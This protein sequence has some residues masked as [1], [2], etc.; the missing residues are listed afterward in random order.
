MT[1]R[2]VWE[3][4][5]EEEEGRK[6]VKKEKKRGG[7]SLARRRRRGDESVKER[8]VLANVDPKSVGRPPTEG[9][10]AVVGPPAG[11]EKRGATGAKGVA[12]E[13][14]GQRMEPGEVPSAGRDRTSRVEPQ[15]GLKRAR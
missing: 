11:S 4:L 13:G 2:T 7:S 9:L 10:D 5:R 12:T 15:K 3:Y 8:G 1:A 6:E 14:K